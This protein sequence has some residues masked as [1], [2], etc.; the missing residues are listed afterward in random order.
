[1][2]WSK[3]NVCRVI[4]L[5]IGLILAFVVA[6]MIKHARNTAEFKKGITRFEMHK[7]EDS[8]FTNAYV[9]Y[10]LDPPSVIILGYGLSLSASNDLESLVKTNFFPQK[11]R[12]YYKNE[13]EST[14]R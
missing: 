2:F 14:N 9:S 12:I 5:V 11:V 3:N 10:F 7:K 1:M 4:L 13:P 6:G 8:R